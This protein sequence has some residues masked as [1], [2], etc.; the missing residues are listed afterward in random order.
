LP[1]ADVARMRWLTNGV[2]AVF[3]CSKTP[4]ELEVL[5]QRLLWIAPD[6]AKRGRSNEQCLVPRYEIS[7]GREQRMRG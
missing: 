7:S 1:G 3:V 4:A 2:L 5:H 6:P